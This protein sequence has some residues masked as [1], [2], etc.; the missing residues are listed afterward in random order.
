MRLQGFAMSQFVLPLISVPHKF[1]T[2]NDPDNTLA[3]MNAVKAGSDAGEWT[4]R[5]AC[6]KHYPFGKGGDAARTM[7]AS[8]A[9]DQ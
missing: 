7:Y 4:M 6:M 2:L 9:M 1:L 5:P 8:L 3:A